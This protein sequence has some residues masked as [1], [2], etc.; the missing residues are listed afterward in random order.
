LGLADIA[1]IFLSM[2]GLCLLW[3]MLYYGNLNI[4]KRLGVNTF[5]TYIVLF[6]FNLVT[7]RLIVADLMYMY[8]SVTSLEA[9][10]LLTFLI[11]LFVLAVMISFV[12]MLLMGVS[13]YS[14]YTLL[15]LSPL[16]IIVFVFL[17]WIALL[18][19]IFIGYAVA[20]IL[21]NLLCYIFTVFVNPATIIV[22]LIF[23]SLL[24]VYL[25]L[26][27]AGEEYLRIYLGRAI[28]ESGKALAMFLSLQAINLILPFCL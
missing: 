24:V 7:L 25:I 11:L 9:V 12:I 27:V 10:D 21:L 20:M 4:V 17:V 6:T 26:K 5:S 14:I 2:I 23:A 15:I 13:I 8:W 18:G 16:T 19:G 28:G 22:A 1:N 3:S